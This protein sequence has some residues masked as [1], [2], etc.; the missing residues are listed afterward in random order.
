MS[1]QAATQASLREAAACD[2]RYLAALFGFRSLAMPG[3]AA[4]SVQRLK[5]VHAR[6]HPAEQAETYSPSPDASPP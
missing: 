5:A 1:T 6:F 2:L 4:V 3:Y